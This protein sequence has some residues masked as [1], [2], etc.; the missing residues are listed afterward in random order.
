MSTK[1]YMIDPVAYLASDLT[2]LPLQ[3]RQIL[4][5][6]NAS[7]TQQGMR[8]KDIV[9]LA[10]AQFGLVTKQDHRVLYAWYARSNENCGVYVA[11][12]R[13]VVTAPAWADAKL[14]AATETK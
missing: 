7:C 5:A 2:K 14:W 13:P 10:V 9:T 11:G 4:A 8:G 6:M 12:S 1:L 3:Q